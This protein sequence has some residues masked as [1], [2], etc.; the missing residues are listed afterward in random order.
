LSD[1]A[2]SALREIDLRP[3]YLAAALRTRAAKFDPATQ[4]SRVLGVSGVGLLVIG[5]LPLAAVVLAA[6]QALR[7]LTR[8][9]RQ[10]AERAQ[11][12]E[13]GQRAMRACL[14]RARD[15][16]QARMQDY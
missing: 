11:M 5:E 13:T 14:D 2:A 4:A 6:S 7:F 8:G 1:A 15:E 16:L 10:E 3:G 12:V 9:R